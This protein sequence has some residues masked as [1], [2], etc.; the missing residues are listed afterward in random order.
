MVLVVYDCCTVSFVHRYTKLALF[1]SA[2][3]GLMQQLGLKNGGLIETKRNTCNTH[4]TRYRNRKTFFCGTDSSWWFD[5]SSIS[6]MFFGKILDGC[7]KITS[8]GVTSQLESSSL[9]RILAMVLRRAIFFAVLS[10]STK[11]ASNLVVEMLKDKN[12]IKSFL[13]KSVRLF[14]DFFSA[15]ILFGSSDLYGARM[16]FLVTFLGHPVTSGAALRCVRTALC[17]ITIRCLIWKMALFS[18]VVWNI[19][20]CWSN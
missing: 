6:V 4:L 12:I 19:S 5:M 18:L 17:P 14:P 1:T 9:L 7:W 3:M 20:Y 8:L 15:E 13:Q 10:W 16:G 11:T 2:V